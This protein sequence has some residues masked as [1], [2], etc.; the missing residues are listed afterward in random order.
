MSAL[1]HIY[2]SLDEYVALE[3]ASNARY[4][5]HDG[6]IVLMSGGSLSHEIIGSN[7]FFALRSRLRGKSCRAFTGG[8]PLDVPATTPYRYPDASVVCGKPEVTKFRGIDRLVNPTLIVEVLSP[9][10]EAYDRG[11]KFTEY[12][13]IPTFAEY[14]LI[15]QD[16]PAV[17]QCVRRPDGSWEE[18]VWTGLD[19]VIALESVGCEVS[20][21]EIYETVEF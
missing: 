4:E 17:T 1:P 5:W 15:A 9:T 13:S 2:F 20:L 18:R 16:R 8:M 12:Q 21:S 11:E 3:K 7:A 19:A 14:L 6:V 10:T